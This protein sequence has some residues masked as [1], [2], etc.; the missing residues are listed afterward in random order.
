MSEISSELIKFKE[1]VSPSISTMRTSASNLLNKFERLYNINEKVKNGVD[2]HYKCSKK[3]DILSSFDDVN[4]ICTDVKRNLSSDINELLSMS[5]DLV[6]KV[7]ELESLEKEIETL[8]SAI[9][10]TTDSARKLQQQ[11][12][13]NELKNRFNLNTTSA[14]DLLTKLKGYGG[15]ATKVQS[16]KLANTISEK[17]TGRSFELVDINVDGTMMKCYVYVPKY[18]KDVGK[19][20]VMMYMYGMDIDNNHGTELMTYGGLGKLIHD[21]MSP[22]GIVVIPYVQNGRLYESKGFR[23]KLAKIPLKVCEKYNGDTSRISLG[24]TS[25]GAVTSYRLVDENPGIFSSIMAVYGVCSIKNINNF[26]N[27]KIVNITGRG[28]SNNTD[29]NFIKKVSE[30]LKTVADVSFSSYD[31]TWNHTNTGTRAFAERD[32]KGNLIVDDVINWT[33]HIIQKDQTNTRYA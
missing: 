29:I 21:G 16:V 3:A 31:D 15:T 5:S 27:M 24:G 23:D 20:P 19:L 11:N 8:R 25:Y 26:K 13:L 22:S 14:K 7:T 18:E 28:G 30:Q 10:I 12:Q 6:A 9:N 32:K 1:T 2:S 33:K 4:S 17:L